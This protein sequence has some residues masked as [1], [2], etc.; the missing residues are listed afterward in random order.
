VRLREVVAAGPP[1][2]WPVRVAVSGVVSACIARVFGGGPAEIGVAAAIGLLVGL[3]ALVS[4]RTVAGAHVFDFV[5]AFVAASVAHAA[6]ALGLELSARIATLAGVVSMI[7]G[8]AMTVAMNEVASRHIIAGTARL[9]AAAL[10]FL[11][12]LVGWALGERLTAALLG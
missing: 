3:L 2:P 12:I 8:L 9:T 5:G 4:R 6:A 7:P 1:Y 11:E 10:V